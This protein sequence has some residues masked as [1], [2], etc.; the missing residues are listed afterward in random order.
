VILSTRMM[1]SR[2]RLFLVVALLCVLLGGFAGLHGGGHDDAAGVCGVAGLG[3]AIA[4]AIALLPRIAGRNHSPRMAVRS[5][6]PVDGPSRDGVALPSALGLA[7]LC[8]L[9]V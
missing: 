7:A 2:R 8:R 4:V 5:F 6:A 1:L 9:R 3:C